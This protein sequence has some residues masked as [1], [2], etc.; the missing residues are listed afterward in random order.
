MEKILCREPSIFYY[1]KIFSDSECDRI[2]NFTNGK[3]A[4]SLIYNYNLEKDN[5][6]DRRT[7]SSFKDTNNDLKFHNEKVFDII[8]NKFWYIK[9]FNLNCLEILQ[10]TQYKVDQEYKNHHDYSNTPSNVIS[11][12]DRISTMIVY[13][14]DNFEGGETHFPHL[15]IK[16]KPFKGSA[17]F[18]EYKYIHELNDLTL[19][20]GLPVTSG[21]K[22]IATTW[23]R[24]KE[25]IPS[26]S[27]K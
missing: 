13:L 14:N 6:T 2:L 5:A 9:N 27:D 26:N 22:Y 23:I 3:Y 18:F 15:N 20:A 8:K 4:E 7:S 10:V 21:T 16:I 19:H 17:V 11:D 1:H 12:N 24:S 25:I